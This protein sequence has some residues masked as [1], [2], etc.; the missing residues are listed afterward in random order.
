MNDDHT[1]CV[2]INSFAGNNAIV[3]RRCYNEATFYLTINAFG[4]KNISFTEK[5]YLLVKFVEVVYKECLPETLTP[6]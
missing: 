5:V 3:C 2:G 1:C 6:Q 4:V